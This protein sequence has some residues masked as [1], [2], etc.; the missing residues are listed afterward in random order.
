LPLLQAQIA[1]FTAI[2]TALSS[3]DWC[4]CFSRCPEL[5]SVAPQ[6]LADRLSKLKSLMAVDDE[7]LVGSVTKAP[8]LL[9]HAPADIA[10]KVGLLMGW[11]VLGVS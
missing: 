9:Q 5:I 6:V 1:K 3:E 2:K 7:Q 11:P 10:E 8:S 4:S